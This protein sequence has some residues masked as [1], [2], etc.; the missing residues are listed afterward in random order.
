VR[1][2]VFCVYLANV[3]CDLER[4]RIGFDQVQM[5]VLKDFG[6]ETEDQLDKIQEKLS[7][8]FDDQRQKFQ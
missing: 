2:I 1:D 4:E 5:Q 3:I 8:L 6:I 7:K